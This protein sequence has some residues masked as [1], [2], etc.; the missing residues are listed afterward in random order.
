MPSTA[1]GQPH[2]S[3]RRLACARS[4]DRSAAS[5]SRAA[6]V[7]ASAWS[8]TARPRH[9]QVGAGEQAR[10]LGPRVQ[11]PEEGHRQAGGTP[12][13]RAAAR[14]VAGH[15][16]PDPHA[17]GMQPGRRID[18]SFD[19][20]LHGQ[21]AAVHQQDV[22]TTGQLRAQPLV[23]PGRGEMREV[24]AEWHP[25]HIAGADPVELRLGERGGAH[26]R[27]E[28][29]RE[30]GVGPV[31]QPAGGRSRQ[32]HL[33]QQPVQ[34]LV[35]DHHA[36]YPAARGPRPEAAKG[37]PVGHLHPVRAQPLQ[38]P[39]GPARIEHPVPAGFR[40]SPAPAA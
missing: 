39:L 24:D 32:S 2:C 18:A 13:Q 27:V 12:L 19:V 4:T 23:A 1:A 16:E 30:P 29:C 3:A 40:G 22:G 17:R 20:L 7:N 31:G 25:P 38:Q 9:H 11:K 36:R 26:H 14:P 6:A 28:A 37:Q 15:H 34:P 10:D 21:P 5:S 35:G 33:V 8:A